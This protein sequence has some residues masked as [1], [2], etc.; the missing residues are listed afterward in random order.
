MVDVKFR[1]RVVANWSTQ[2]RVGACIVGAVIAAALIGP[3]LSPWDPNAPDVLAS[4]E[5][6]S[7]AHWMGTDSAGRDVL[8]RTLVG[9]QIS[10]LA[11]VLITIATVTIGTIVGS[12]V[13]YAGGWVDA[14]LSRVVDTA[15]AIPF[16]VV[17]LATVAILGV[18]TV[19]VGLGMVL[20]GWAVYARLARAEVLSLREHE[21][22][23]ATKSLGYSPARILFRH[24]IPNVIRPSL[25]FATMDVVAAM[26]LLAAMSYLGFGTQPPVADLGSII[27]GGQPFLLTAWWISTLPAV[28][29]IALGVGVGMIDDGFST[30]RKGK[31]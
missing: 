5:H 31:R 11:G 7:F 29:L 25:T 2:T 1:S 15:I 24:V 10:L 27:A 14:F 23:M 9:T 12:L 13:A 3:I 18:G 20:V 22:I 21:F 16:I 8:T 19:S 6:P 28:V 30:G 17:V 4:L 26:V